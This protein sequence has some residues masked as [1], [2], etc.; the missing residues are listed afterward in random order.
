MNIVEVVG[1]KRV[2]DKY[3]K[4]DEGFIK[5]T[6]ELTGEEI[7]Y[8]RF[9]ITRPDAV[10]IMLYNSDSDSV[11]LVKQHRF[12]VSD[13]VEDNL[14]EIVA[15]KIDGDE[16][17]IDAAIREV[18]EEV[19]YDI[20]EGNIKFAFDF[21]VSPGYSTEKIYLFLAKVNDFDKTD[22]GGGV[23]GEHENIEI[24]NMP[25]AEFFQGVVDGVILDSKT[26]HGAQSLWQ[27]RNSHLIEAGIKYLEIQRLERAREIADKVIN[28]DDEE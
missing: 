13:R 6:N 1:E 24:V 23:E 22:E 7:M 19:G 12:A 20:Q 5:E 15:G 27:V 4:V 9:K 11:I 25:V 17:P 3:L 21:Y 16:N 2:Y 8:S 18:K 26:L 10:A 14:L 28:E